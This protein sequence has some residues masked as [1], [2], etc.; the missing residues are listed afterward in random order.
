MSVAAPSRIARL[1]GIFRPRRITRSRFRRLRL[2]GLPWF[3]EALDPPKP[4]S[5]QQRAQTDLRRVR[6]RLPPKRP[7]G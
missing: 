5:A 6:E 4:P 3:G 2:F 7:S 1:A